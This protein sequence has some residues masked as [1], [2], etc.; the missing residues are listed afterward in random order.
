MRVVKYESSCQK[1][2]DDFVKIS[3]NGTFLF[4]RNFMDYHCDRFTD[5]SL[6]IYE[7]N[8]IIALLPANQV[9]D[10]VYSH[11]GLSYGGF[12]VS[13]EMRAALMLAVF[14][15]VIDF[16]KANDIKQ[17]YYKC[18]PYIYHKQPA[19]E[20]LYA[21]FRNRAVLHRR[22]ISTVI[23]NVSGIKFSDNTKRNIKKALKLNIVVGESD[24]FED[25]HKILSKVLER[26]RAKPV[27]TIDE[28]MLLNRFFPKNIKLYAAFE[29][30]ELIAGTI[31]F[32]TGKVMHTQYLASSDRG[33]ETGALDL[34][35]S[36]LIKMVYKNRDYFSFGPST[37]EQG[38]VL[39][40]GLIRQKEGFGGR[41]IVHDFY[42]LTIA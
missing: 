31:V 25:Y 21:L 17:F 33:R 29:N 34:V 32:D 13:S 35:V 40:E 27:H 2:W 9:G 1:D 18:I 41:S 42:K 24:R 3:K 10:E 26:H 5:C 14:E 15:S 22:D 28:I 38:W 30:D 7:K 37:E 39:N 36:N 11:L 19:E 12:V 4:E 8:K 6:I 16:F 23:G 20:D